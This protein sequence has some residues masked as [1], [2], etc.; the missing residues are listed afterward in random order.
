MAR[1]RRENVS[2]KEIEMAFEEEMLIQAEVEGMEYLNDLKDLYEEYVECSK[3]DAGCRYTNPMSFDEYCA[4][5]G[6]SI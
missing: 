3:F 1:T 2:Q 4:T 5:H 6:I